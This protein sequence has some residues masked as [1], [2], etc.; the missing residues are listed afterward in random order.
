M[1]NS[2]IS[3]E[4]VM[5]MKRMYRTVLTDFAGSG[6]S[7]IWKM[8]SKKQMNIHEALMADDDSFTEILKDP[9]TTYLYFGID[10]IFPDR[11][12]LDETRKTNLGIQTKHDIAVLAAALGAVRE[13]NPKG[14]KKL[15]PGPAKPVEETL[16][17]IETIVGFPLD[18]P[19]PFRGDH[20]LETSK[21]SISYR[22]VQSL[23]QAY[24]IKAVAGKENARY[25]EIGGGTG[26]VAF[27][28]NMF[29]MNDYTIVDLPMTIIAQAAFLSATLGPD[30]IWMVGDPMNQQKGR[31]RLVPPKF[32]SETFER[33][34]VML[35]ADSFTEMDINHAKGY[36]D[37]AMKNTKALVSINHESNA[38]T[39]SDIAPV[40]ARS[41]SPYWLR[42]GYVEEIFTFD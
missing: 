20:G 1:E 22:A 28:A 40:L 10:N 17:A 7:D 36:F 2:W 34:D 30:A 41:R 38:Y 16:D 33:F 25:L 13:F 18:F 21:G 11:L 14:G 15:Q 9:G 42:P 5:R 8:I 24:R 12:D 3:D 39:V 32:I 4:V 27:F 29:G 6:T 31:I 26:R 37:F 23:Y 19:A 35:N